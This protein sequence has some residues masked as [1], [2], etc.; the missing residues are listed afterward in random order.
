MVFSR[1]RDRRDSVEVGWDVENAGEAMGESSV[2]IWNMPS[3]G[4]SGRGEVTWAD[5]WVRI[6][7]W[8]T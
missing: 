7:S 1:R 5:T 3:K 6:L 2:E 8:L 4:R